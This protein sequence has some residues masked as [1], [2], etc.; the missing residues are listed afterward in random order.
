MA[1]PRRAP[2]NHKVMLGQL[3]DLVLKWQEIALDEALAGRGDEKAH[4]LADDVQTYIGALYSVY[5]KLEQ[6]EQEAN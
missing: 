5:S 1:K 6:D 3:R 2:L 4:R